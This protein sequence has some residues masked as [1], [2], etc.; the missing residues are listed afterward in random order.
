MSVVMQE[1][2][3]AMEASL[4]SLPANISM[5]GTPLVYVLVTACCAKMT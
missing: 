1:Q 5:Q 2:S 3:S 4:M